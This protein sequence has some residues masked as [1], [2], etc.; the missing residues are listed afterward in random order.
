MKIKKN[1]Y[2]KILLW[3]YE[4]TNKGFTRKEIQETFNLD[5]EQIEWQLRL[6]MP[7]NHN[8]RLIDH[9]NDNKEPNLLALTDKGMSAAV[10]HLEL[11]QARFLSWVAIA[12]GVLALVINI[13][14]IKYAQ[15]QIELGK[16]SISLAIEPQIEVFIKRKNINDKENFII[17]IENNGISSVKDLRVDSSVIQMNK[18]SFAKGEVDASSVQE[19]LFTES[20][21]NPSDQGQRPV[22]IENKGGSWVGVLY[23]NLSY[24][25]DV[26]MK[27]FNQRVAFFTDGFG[28]YSFDEIKDVPEMEPIVRN[29]KL[30]TSQHLFYQEL[31]GQPF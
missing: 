14:T 6:F 24:K 26:D 8:D 18:N 23:L 15:T 7:A 20:E 9:H 17:G 19:N 28:I 22:F 4:K 5:N 11:R 31:Y 27:K 13:M 30:Y 16:K 21:F 2:T 12:I 29:F 25:R 3:A 10:K 1:I